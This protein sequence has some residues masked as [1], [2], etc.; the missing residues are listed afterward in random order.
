MLPVRVSIG[1]PGVT[2]TIFLEQVREPCS[3]PDPGF[4]DV[5]VKAV[6]LNTKDIYSIHGVAET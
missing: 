6:G 5:A 3:S 4:I 1:R 2:D